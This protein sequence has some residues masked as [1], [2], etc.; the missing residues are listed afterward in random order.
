MSANGEWIRFISALEK[1]GISFTQVQYATDRVQVIRAAAIT[2]ALS[3][4]VVETEWQRRVPRDGSGISA[5][6]DDTTSIGAG[7]TMLNPP[8][9]LSPAGPSTLSSP[10]VHFDVSAQLPSLR[11]PNQIKYLPE[12]LQDVVLAK[13]VL[14]AAVG[15][16]GSFLVF[17]TAKEAGAGAAPYGG[18]GFRISPHVPPAMRSL[19]ETVLPV[20]DAFVVLR[21]MEEAEYRSRSLVLMALGEVVSEITTSYAHQISRLH[22]WSE[23]R[24]M[25]L[26]G[27]VSEVLRVGHHV[28]RLRQVLPMDAMEAA[29]RETP[30]LSS[31][32]A[33]VGTHGVVG[34]RVL[35]HLCDQVTKYSG[36]REDHE[37]LL[38]LLRR[39]LVPYLHMLYQWMH[40]GV[41]EDPYGEFFISEVY[42]PAR[43]APTAASNIHQRHVGHLFL[44]SLTPSSIA[45]GGGVDG[46]GGPTRIAGTSSATAQQDVVAFE[47]RFSLN[48]A[49]LPTFLQSPSRI[50]KMIFFA[51]KYCCLLREYGVDLPAFHSALPFS[52]STDG[53]GPNDTSDAAASTNWSGV[54][55]LHRQVQESFETASGAVIQLLFG[56]SVDLLGHLTSLKL[57]FLQERGD[58]VMDFLESAESMLA[59]SSER[60]KAHSLQVILQASIAR[61]SGASDPYHDLIGCSFAEA[62]LEE[63]LLDQQQRSGQGSG[64]APATSERQS[65]RSVGEADMRQSMEMLQLEADLQ[66]PLTLVLDAKVIQ[67]LNII[68]RLLL[69]IKRCE[70]L[71]CHLWRVNEVLA[72]FSSAYVIKHQLAQFLRQ[73]QFYASHFV[74][75]PLWSR[76][77]GRIGQADSVFSISQALTDFF[78]GVETGLVLSS[79]Q[80]FR[81][82]ARIL[83]LTERFCEIGL[84]TSTATMP[85]IEAT[86][87]SVEDQFLHSLSELASPVG[88]D[89]PQLVPLLTWIDFSRFYDEN[90][91][92]HV[93]HGSGVL[94]KGSM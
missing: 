78:D 71:L 31:S 9:Q 17:T 80:R 89:Y 23:T 46:G 93:Q 16:G 1:K 69:R 27:V 91:V 53:G 14:A 43:P 88:A 38:L 13:E 41:L 5:P 79:P 92:Y 63:W 40:A 73:L 26:M 75:E 15:L 68:F 48:K 81:S 12:E 24:P 70:R 4:A 51:G 7:A 45:A 49:M 34:P 90:N 28:V 82:L 20:A 62:T 59:D 10:A 54:D 33:S 36:S 76:L 19:C 57:F 6:A 29:L 39:S 25:P 65:R 77:V 74:L 32:S 42:R 50:A 3:I 2:D 94:G 18:S 8:S 58:W 72:E 21:Q 56:P 83:E 86:M 37:L 64:N 30:P 55:Q 52:G 47:R 61:S 87:H 67:R 22:A 11:D 85:L 60:I 84:H 35:N 66:W 44:G